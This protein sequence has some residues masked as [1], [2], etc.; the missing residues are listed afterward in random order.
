[1][2]PKRRSG[3]LLSIASETGGLLPSAVCRDGKQG[4]RASQA[5]SVCKAGVAMIAEMSVLRAFGIG[6]RRCAKVKEYTGR[7]TAGPNML[8]NTIRHR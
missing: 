2:K 6:G 1:M 8:P 5:V 7:S 3:L 4:L